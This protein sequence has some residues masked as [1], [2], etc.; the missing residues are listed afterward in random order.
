MTVSDD[1]LWNTAPGSDNSSNGTAERDHN[2]VSHGS[3]IGEPGR[4]GEAVSCDI[5]ARWPTRDQR[6]RLASGDGRSSTLPTRA[7]EARAA[8]Y[9]SCQ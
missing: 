3:R 9:L 5:P 6:P 4:S 2:R 8:S 1:L 7:L